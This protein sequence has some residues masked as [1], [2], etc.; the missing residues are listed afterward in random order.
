MEGEKKKGEKN[1]GHFF[2]FCLLCR[3]TEAGTEKKRGGERKGGMQRARDRFES[4]TFKRL[5][6]TKRHGGGKR[7][8]GK[9]ENKLLLIYSRREKEKKKDGHLASRPLPRA[10]VCIFP[11]NAKGGGGGGEDRR[12]Y[13]CDLNFSF[14]A[15]I[16]EQPNSVKG[17]EKKKREGERRI[18]ESF[19]PR[20]GIR[21][22]HKGGGAIP[23]PGPS[24]DLV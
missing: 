6:R 22:R 5:Q 2:D 21:D 1:L 4:E 15:S 13:S 23:F 19:H 12:V 16:H 8:V 17:R 20:G 24:G 3:G 9:R 11:R 10:I 7:K 14:S 18:T